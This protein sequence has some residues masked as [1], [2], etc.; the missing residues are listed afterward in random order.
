MTNKLKKSTIS[1][2]DELIALQTKKLELL[3]MH[4]KGLLQYLIDK[5]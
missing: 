3:K 1:S 5:K 2:I 4:R